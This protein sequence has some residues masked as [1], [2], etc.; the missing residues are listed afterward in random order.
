VG[1]SRVGLPT[2][3][4]VLGGVAD[5]ISEAEVVATNA[6]RRIMSGGRPD[7]IKR[8]AVLAAVQTASRRL[9]RWP[10]ARLDRRSARRGE[11]M[12][13]RAEKRHPQPNRETSNLRGIKKLMPKER[14]GR[15]DQEA[16]GS[17]QS[18]QGVGIYGVAVSCHA[19]VEQLSPFQQDANNAEH[20][21]SDAAQGTDVGMAA[22]SASYRLLL[23]GSFCTA[24]R[25]QWITASRNRA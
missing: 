22:C 6:P 11:I 20:P 17:A 13:A 10:L 21:V 19:G 5:E 9:R 4:Q 1:L 18:N 3:C 16:N 12:Q 14:A 25:A 2:L 15:Q 23:F 24:T 7:L 8:R